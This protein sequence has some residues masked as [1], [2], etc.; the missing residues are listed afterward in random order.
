MQM[1]ISPINKFS[2]SQNPSKQAS[3]KSDL[4]QRIFITAV[5]GSGLINALRASAEGDKPAIVGKYFLKTLQQT[6]LKQ[7]RRL[8]GFDIDDQGKLMTFIDKDRNQ[9]FISYTED[10]GE[11]H[12]N[13]KEVHRGFSLFGLGARKKAEA[14]DYSYE[15]EPAR[16][17]KVKLHD[18]F[19][20][21]KPD[22]KNSSSQHYLLYP[23]SQEFEKETSIFDGVFRR[24]S[25]S[26]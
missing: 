23:D 22:T 13:Y 8:R 15:S 6:L 20:H 26:V 12:L 24:V 5:Q 9:V 4:E 3:F 16:V 17:R 19:K 7:F 14:I 2:L 21:D 11:P 18:L 25:S 1:Q 10:F